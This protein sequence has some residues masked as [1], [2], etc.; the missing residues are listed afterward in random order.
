M[1]AR[2]RVN[3]SRRLN[4]SSHFR[5]GRTRGGRRPL[6]LQQ[7]QRGLEAVDQL[8]VGMFRANQSAARATTVQVSLRDSSDALHP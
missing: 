1:D 7:R 8:P 5:I 3:L 2:E 4:D 6:R